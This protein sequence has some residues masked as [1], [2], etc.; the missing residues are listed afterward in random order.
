M[1]SLDAGTLADT[2]VRLGILT[3]R[4][5]EEASEDLDRQGPGEEFLRWMERKGYLTPFQS[6]KLL[7]GDTE[8][9][10]MGGYRI[11]YK[12][13]SGSFGRV[14]RADDPSSGRTVAIKVLRDRWSKDP[15]KV[16]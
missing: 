2:S 10:V 4:Q 8:G 11:L 9:Y 6:S 5:A 3:F 13:S 16:E 12:V 14:Y 1:S 7:K 15:H